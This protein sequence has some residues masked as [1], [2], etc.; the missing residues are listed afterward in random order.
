VRT[1][2]KRDLANQVNL[3]DYPSCVIPVTFADKDIDKK[4]NSYTPISDLD[5]LVWDKCIHFT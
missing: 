1:S 3:I 2:P 4:D 5:K